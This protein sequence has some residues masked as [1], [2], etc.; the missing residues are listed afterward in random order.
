MGYQG[1]GFFHGF[2]ME[3]LGHVTAFRRQPYPDGTSVLEIGE[4]FHQATGLQGVHQL[5]NRGRLDPQ[6]GSQVADPEAGIG[7]LPG[8]PRFVGFMGQAV[9]QLELPGPGSVAESR[10]TFERSYSPEGFEQAF[11]ELTGGV[12]M[13]SVHGCPLLGWLIVSIPNYMWSRDPGHGV[14]RAFLI[15]PL[16]LKLGHD[17]SRLSR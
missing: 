3:G 4:T 12:I 15:K 16:V 13:V 7:S 1:L 11:C 9:D 17:R 8:I 2:G 14:F 5:G 6:P 10:P